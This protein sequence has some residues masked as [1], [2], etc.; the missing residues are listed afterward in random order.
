MRGLSFWL[1]HSDASLTWG[2]MST[3]KAWWLYSTIRLALF[4]GVFALVWMLG[5]RWWLAA[6]LA[7]LISMAISIIVLDPV[8]QRAAEGLQDWRDRDR[9]EDSVLEDEMV[10]EDPSLLDRSEPV[11]S[12]ETEAPE[13]DAD[14]A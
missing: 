9:T 7:A 3:R 6:V 1:A 2:T 4:A 12:D 14:R 8:R 5:A 13:D 11:E 10:D